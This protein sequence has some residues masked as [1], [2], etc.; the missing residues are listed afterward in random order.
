MVLPASIQSF[1]DT[2]LQENKRLLDENAELKSKLDKV[3]E[4]QIQLQSQLAWLMRK[5]FGSMSEKMAAL[6]PNQLSLNFSG[7]NI[8]L[9]AQQAAIEA[10]REAAELDI[11]KLSTKQQ[12]ATSRPLRSDVM[13]DLP[14]IEV[15]IEPIGV[16]LSKYKR[17]GEEHTKVLEFKPGELY[18]TDYIRPKYAL[19]DQISLPEDGQKS[20]VI[21]PMPLLPINKGI[22][23]ASLLTEILM[24]KYV[25]HLPFYRQIEQFKLSGVR[26][27]A[28]TVNG[29]FTAS[30]QLLEPLYNF[31][32]NRVLEATYIQVDETTVP[33]LDREK[34]KAN[35][36]YLWVARAVKEKLL[37]FSYDNG[38]RSQATAAKLL[39]GFKGYL[40]SDGFSGYNVFED[41]PNIALVACWA[42]C[43]RKFEE[44]LAENK[45]MAE[46]ALGQIQ[47]LYKIE[48]KAVEDN[49]S[50]EEIALQRQKLAG[51]ILDAFQGW[52][53]A[54]YKTV[55]P[56]SR[57]GEAIK[58]TYS[59]Y[60][61]LTRYITDG[62]LLIDNNLAEN[63]IRPLAISRKNFLFCGNHQA[64][65]QA[66]IILTLMGCCKEVGVN[67]RD[68]LNDV[69]SKMPYNIQEKN[70]LEEL[71]PSVWS[72]N[73]QVEGVQ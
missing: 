57:M 46:Y 29:W 28:S 49:L 65:G 17:I 50:Y 62:A 58:Y 15:V 37:F 12:K 44:S 38:S 32:R 54:N 36:E 25:F 47:L 6:D 70:N 55:L 30:S 68:W 7:T 52:L 23:G 43:R 59:L 2:T 53:E 4:N 18:V 41:D 13:K 14:T 39:N 61:R 72:A 3:L 9:Q 31:I 69:I 71:L 22:A 16:D 64:A 11:Q 27:P 42:H 60:P 40:Q 19:K 56:K 8:P 63:A 21:A 73:R 67:P 34:H 24:Q 33:V 10:A 51:P 26:L 66:A 1:I 35:K 20:V 48:R 45:A 5:M